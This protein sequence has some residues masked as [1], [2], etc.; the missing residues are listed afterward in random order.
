MI[1]LI[2]FIIELSNTEH[3]YLETSERDTRYI[4]LMQINICVITEPLKTTNYVSQMILKG[5]SIA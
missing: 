2:T 5:D 3:F 4:F 1:L